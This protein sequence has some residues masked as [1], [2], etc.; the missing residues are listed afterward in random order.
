LKRAP[1]VIAIHGHPRPA[2]R[3]DPY[4]CQTARFAAAFEMVAR[5]QL[6]AAQLARSLESDGP[7]APGELDFELA[8]AISREVWGQGFAAPV[9]D[10]VFAVV[11]Q[12]I[13]GGAHSKLTLA[14]G[15]ERFDAILFRHALPLPFIRAAYRPDVNRGTARFCS[16]LDC[17]G[18][19]NR[20][21]ALAAPAA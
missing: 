13:V 16:M 1:G 10:D 9:F 17:L 4:R 6:S 11:D 14:R 3:V 8:A 12:R 21:T 19:L 18:R 2:A 5:E 7:L 20:A 15:N